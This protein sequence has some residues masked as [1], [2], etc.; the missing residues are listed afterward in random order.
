M[1]TSQSPWQSPNWAISSVW[2]IYYHIIDNIIDHL[3]IE[4]YKQALCVYADMSARIKNGSKS[5]MIA[6]NA[7]FCLHGNGG[8]TF[9]TG[10]VRAS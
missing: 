3:D 5:H 10:T 1:T 7:P 4:Y 9:T 8:I 2:A 6:N